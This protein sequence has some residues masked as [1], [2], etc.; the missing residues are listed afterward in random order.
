MHG[1]GRVAVSLIGQW[2]EAD[3]L[4]GL[5]KLV[6]AD[7]HAAAEDAREAWRALVG[8]Q[9]VALGIDGQRIAARVD[10]ATAGQ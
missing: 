4:I 9:R 7:V 1:E 3:R 2:C 8:G 6:G 5:G 10:G